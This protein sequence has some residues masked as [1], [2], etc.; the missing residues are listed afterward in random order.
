[1]STEQPTPPATDPAG[2]APVATS[3]DQHLGDPLSSRE[4]EV[5]MLLVDGSSTKAIAESLF[6]S[7]NTAR[8]HVQRIIRKRGAHSRLEAV[9]I[10]Q[11]RGL[12]SEPRE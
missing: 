1:M 4:R 5:L 7:I 3:H 8:H 9:A 6:I 12:T 10:A 2:E 11:R